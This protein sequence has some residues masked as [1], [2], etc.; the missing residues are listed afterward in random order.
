MNTRPGLP[1]RHPSGV[2]VGLPTR[3]RYLDRRLHM[4][5]KHSVATRIGSLRCIVT[6]GLALLLATF[7]PE[8]QAK[9][10]KI[11]GIYTGSGKP[12]S[13][14]IRPEDGTAGSWGGACDTC[15][16]PLGL[17]SVINITDDSFQPEGTLLAS[18]V[19]P[20]VM[21]GAR[22]GYDAERVFFRCDSGD[23]V[24]EMFSTNADD[25]WSGSD[26]GREA[27]QRMGL[28][29]VYDT[30][31]KHVA[32]RLTH[33]ETGEYF[34]T[35]WKE[36]R[37]TGL[38]T[39]REG[40]QLV[41]AKNL[42]AVRIE[43]Y[44]GNNKATIIN[45]YWYTQ[46]L[47]Y[48]AIKGPG[49]SYPKVGQ[50]HVSNW[51]GWHFNWPGA[52][53]LTSM[54]SLRTSKSCAVSNVTP[55]VRFAPITVA[56]VAA[57]ETRQASFELDFRC[58]SSASSGTGSNANAVGVLVSP[59]SLGAARRLGLVNGNGGVSHLLSDN[60]GQP[61]MA[62]GVGI[63]IER[64]GRTINLLSSE[65]TGSGNAGGWYAVLAGAQQKV[66]NANGVDHYTE[67]FNAVLERL[68]G[69]PLAAGQVNATAQV[70]IR[71]Q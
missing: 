47:G 17:P 3:S 14:R 57:G 9:C 39:D 44:K 56:A 5:D 62:T 11:T 30:A 38:D 4:S 31:F 26:S 69:D 37:L 59:G 15:N 63:R 49:L 53:G 61:G 41:K 1:V 55:V 42:S 25:R 20:L 70:V 22:S 71:V 7:A 10:T 51:S 66:S 46:P 13:D 23:E 8:S 35:V 12:G 21:Y 68:P 19:A 64:N 6:L 60:Y 34:T 50:S 67:S 52:I 18:S 27:G 54:I 48:I 33:L 36:R 2:Y 28:D 16:G 29:A 32:S 24:F 58:Q 43:L 45:N 40:R 65:N